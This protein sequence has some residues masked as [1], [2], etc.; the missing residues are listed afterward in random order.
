MN[1]N[2]YHIIKRV[3]NFVSSCTD[4]LYALFLSNESGGT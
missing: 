1:S 2:D 3:M 4:I